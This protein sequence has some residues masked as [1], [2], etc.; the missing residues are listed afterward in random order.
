MT[1]LAEQVN[2]TSPVEHQPELGT[3]L[4]IYSKQTLG[5]G[6]QTLIARRLAAVVRGIDTRIERVVVRFEDLNGP[7]GGS[8]ISCRIQL[9]LSGRPVIVVEAR[10]ED[11]ARA[12]GLALSSL[13]NALTRRRDRERSRPRATLRLLP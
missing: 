8:D 2:A 4:A 1:R 7:K 6:F 5:S 9:V 13:A 3:H 10:A 11:E 12:F